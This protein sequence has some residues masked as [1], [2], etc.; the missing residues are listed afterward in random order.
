MHINCNKQI[1][2]FYLYQVAVKLGKWNFESINTLISVRTEVLHLWFSS[3]YYIFG[4]HLSTHSLTNSVTAAS[5]KGWIVSIF[6]KYFCLS[7]K[8]AKTHRVVSCLSN[9]Q[10]WLLPASIEMKSALS[11]SFSLSRYLYLSVSRCVANFC[12]LLSILPE[13]VIQM[14]NT[15]TKSKSSGTNALTNECM[16][17]ISIGFG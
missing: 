2:K 12:Y 3:E 17:A 11:L 8:C 15:N 13:H 6:Q 9:R 16:F 10:L 14:V 4:I 5:N 1:V 7:W